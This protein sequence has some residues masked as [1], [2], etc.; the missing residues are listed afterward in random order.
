MFCGCSKLETLDLSAF[1][2]SHVTNME[3][4]FEGCYNL[5]SPGLSTFD[6]ANVTDMKWMFGD[7]S[8]LT[9]LDLPSFIPNT[10]VN[11]SLCFII[12]QNFLNWLFRRSLQQKE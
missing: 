8:S 9:S 5:R 10:T 11:M 3:F 4:V 1:N 7:C 12:V 2:T 6:I